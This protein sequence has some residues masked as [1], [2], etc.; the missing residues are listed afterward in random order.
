MSSEICSEI[1]SGICSG[2]AKFAA[3]NAGLRA[4]ICNPEAEA[5][6]LD[7]VV[8]NRESGT[9]YLDREIRNRE[10]AILN[11]QSGIWNPV[12]AVR[13][14]RAGWLSRRELP[15]SGGVVITLRLGAGAGLPL[16][17]RWRGRHRSL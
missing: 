1:Y 8:S 14:R 3:G 13:P 12:C 10:F 15:L 17:H 16:G 9:C 5:S 7:F 11:L 4:S 6:D 2:A